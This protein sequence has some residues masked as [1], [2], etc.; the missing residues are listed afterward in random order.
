MTN[1]GSTLTSF[2][3]VAA[4]IRD[5]TGRVLLARRPAGRHM[6]GLWE[7]PGAQGARR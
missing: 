1:Q 7:F 2:T 5:D 6:A 4:V 3:V